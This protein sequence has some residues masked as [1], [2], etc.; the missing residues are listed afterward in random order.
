MS[1]VLR[2]IQAFPR[3]R[4]IE[5][6]QAL[7]GN[8][9]CHDQR[10]AV[11][12]ELEHLSATGAIR[13]RGDGKWIPVAPAA[14]SVARNPRAH[15]DGAAAAGSTLVAAPFSRSVRDVADTEILSD[16]ETAGHLD[17]QALLR[18]WRSA[19]RADPRGATTEAPDRIPLS[20]LPVR[21][22]Y[23]CTSGRRTDARRSA[24]APAS[25]QSSSLP[26]I[27]ANRPTPR[28]LCHL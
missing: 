5:E 3:G 17:P 19:L 9:F 8:A 16:T 23:A 27:A 21:L 12:A 25:P 10:L 15:E 1:V 2:T 7:L 18:Y 11:L 4:T 28:T 22:R 13:R 20:R 26:T 6:L 24:S 14:L